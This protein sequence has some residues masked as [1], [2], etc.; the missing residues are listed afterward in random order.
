[1]TIRNL[2]YALR[3]HSIVLIGASEDKGSVGEKLTEN[4]LAGG[5][6]GP[7]YLVNPKRDRIAGREAFRNIDDLPEAPELAVIATPPGTIPRIIADLGRKG[8]RAA[9]VITAG[10]SPELKQAMLDAARP[11]CFRII[12]P[13]SL[14]VWVPALG[15]NANFGMARPKPGKLAFLSQSGALIGGVLDWAQSRGI[16]FSYVVSMGDMTDVDAGDLL[17]FL[18]ADVST[19]AILLYLETIPSARKFMSASRS[20]GRAKPVVVIKSGR[21]AASAKAA[22][23]HTG[24]LAGSDRVV[25]S[26]FRR[27]GLVRVEDLEDLFN[28]AE[29]LTCL[30]PIKGNELLIVTN[31]GGAGVLAVDALIQSGGTLA[32]LSQDLTVKLDTVLP[33][34]W[35]RSNPIDIIG[36]STPERYAAV[37]EA[38]LGDAQ[39][40]AILV[41]N[42]PTALASSTRAAEAVIGAVE[43]QRKGGRVPPILTNWLGVEGASEARVKFQEAGIPTFD[44]PNDAVR[45]FGYLWQYAK[46]QEALLRTPPR[47][48]DLSS[49]DPKAALAVM[50]KAGLDG[51]RML[52]EP[53]AKKVLAAYGIPTV[54]TRIATALDEVEEIAADLLQQ[55]QGLA[56]KV[57]S[58]DISH[59]SDVGGV[60]LGLRSAAEARSAAREIKDRMAK[61]RPEAKLEGFTVQPMIVLPQAHELL[62]G[63]SED[64]LFGPVI[65]FGAGGTAAELVDDTAVALPPLDI[66]LA[67]SLME[68]TRIFKLLKGY[69]DRAS[70]ALDAVAD[71]L[72]RLSQ[73]VIDCPALREL[74][75]NPLLADQNGVIALDARI[76]IEPR[77][78]DV[79]GPNPRLAIRPYPNQWETTA[80]TP[81]GMR[82][83]IR[84]IRPADENLYGDFI[85]KLSPEDIRFRFLSPR[86]E[87][88][89]QFIA[90]FT[91]IDYARAMA[92]VALPKNQQELLGVA[93][94]AA[95][96]D[97][98]SAEY[99]IIVRSDLKGRGLGFLLMRH[100]IRYAES[101]GFRNLYGGVLAEN[102]RMLKMC[103]DLGFEVT[104]DPEDLGL[105]KVR[106]KFPLGISIAADLY[107]A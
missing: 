26:A 85:A 81:E 1:M 24:A 59:K 33:L 55:G 46:A 79:P 92:F 38:V 5:F 7:I 45:G 6:E 65:L 13:N 77:E 47:E 20:A 27:A 34:N 9:I 76:G 90:R 8:A 17:D 48:A 86:K 50:R 25:A 54:P 30:K 106:L 44:S 91:Q 101:E 105:R 88:S 16:G 75:I 14:G 70:A 64:R 10:L 89:H 62:L 53:E 18:A 99:A 12:G 104:P 49:I 94:L 22:A 19:S 67:R 102:E 29:T 37:M 23:T 66:E 95:D 3:P 71:S 103:R 41:M 60:R 32:G 73:L 84:P 15:V 63:V 74:D 51:R 39:A 96:P 107:S 11:T 56:V 72:V 80:E 21:S 100:L 2:E 87:F 28:A 35:S 98:R 31:G 36:D 40:N 82:V 69:R 68:Q 57:L 52:T 58:K 43:K 93:R 4:A 61:L 78:L 97:Y 42:C 83:F